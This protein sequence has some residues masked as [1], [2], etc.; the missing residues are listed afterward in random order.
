MNSSQISWTINNTLTAVGVAEK[1]F[2]YLDYQ[3]KVTSQSDS[4]G[5]DVYREERM[6][7]SLSNVEFNYPTRKEVKV[8]HNIN[9]QIDQGQVV[10]LVGSSG[11]G[12]STIIQ[13]VQRLYDISSGSLLINS[14][15]IKDINLTSLRK[16][17]GFVSQEPILFSG[18]IEENIVYGVE[19]Y[20]QCWLKECC[21]QS[22]CLD[23]IQ[24]AKQFPEGFM[25]IVGE[26]GLKLS[27]GQ[28]QRI[29]IA[30]ALIKKPKVLIFDEATSALDAESEG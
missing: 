9:C 24:D 1:L 28:K 3:P 14:H 16:S 22:N 2:S 25:T 30:R 10:A 6:D 7:I 4:E 8:L 13:L 15:D 20:S 26:R 18:T 29:S 23:F 19:E 21:R 11:E 5:I 27:G 17:I 12:K